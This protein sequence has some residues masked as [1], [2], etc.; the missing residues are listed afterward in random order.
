MLDKNLPLYALI[1]FVSLI[2]TAVIEKRIIPLLRGIARQPI[3]E[4]GP[5]W[6]IK[7]SGTPTMGGIAF[8]VAVS[9][10]LSL[11]ALLLYLGGDNDGAV[12]LLLS[13]AFCILNA[14]VGALDDLK[15]LKA[16]QND[17]GLTAKQKLL[18]HFI[19][20]FLFLLARRFLLGD[21][22]SISFSFGEF[23]L[24]IFYLPLCLI[25][26]VGVINCA[27]LT[28]GIDGLASGVAFAVGVSLFYISCALS[29]EVSYISSAIMGA[30]IGFLIFN[31]HPAKIFM[32]DT[33]SLFLGALAVSAVFALSN[34]LLILIIGGVYLL[35]GA[36]VILQVLYYKLTK[37]RLFKMAPLH[38]HLEKSGW[39][40]NTICIAAIL[41]TLALSVIA[42][43]LYLP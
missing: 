24:G 31:L 38:H 21:S 15:K 9:A 33:G 4:S 20:A 22:T 18:F 2:A 26:I 29:T 6:H 19:L 5:R 10:A 11:S 30:A 25:L 37:R 39:S 43:A 40:E 12:S 42:Y 41:F 3:Y 35:E 23:E 28:D 13:V 34:P 8:V 16:K 32:G 1:F 36:S 14:L 7:K 27:N 17:R